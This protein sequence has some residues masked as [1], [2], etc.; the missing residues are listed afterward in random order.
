[1]AHLSRLTNL[2]ILLC[3]FSSYA[4]GLEPKDKKVVKT[5]IDTFKS[6][7]KEAIADLILYP[8]GRGYPIP[9]INNK[10]EMLL[11]FDQLF[12]E[13]L[14]QIVINSDIQKDWGYSRL[15]WIVL[16]DEML[17]LNESGKIL[18][19]N[20][21]TVAE[22]KI[23]QKHIDQRKKQLHPSV[24]EFYKPALEWKTKRFHIRVDELAGD[25]YRYTAWPIGK[26]TIKKPDILIENGKMIFEG[27]DGNRRYEFY[28]GK[29]RYVCSVTEVG[30]PDSAP[31]DLEVYI[32]EKQIVNEPVL[33][34]IDSKRNNG[35]KE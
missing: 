17:L 12:D 11:R 10:K 20:H 32:G 23:K 6:E 35:S 4:Y 9:A 18:A 31:G 24:S 15:K 3:L 34:V 8:L 14:M 7:N 16:L 1:M 5:F 21:Q 29:Y 19:I 25:N 26:K 30:P 33:E 13:T 28:R 22:R 27:M 2:I